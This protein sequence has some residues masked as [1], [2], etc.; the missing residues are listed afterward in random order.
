MLVL[1]RQFYSFAYSFI[2]VKYGS[3]FRTIACA[4]LQVGGE[5]S[6]KKKGENARFIRSRLSLPPNYF[7]F[8]YKQSLSN[9][10]LRFSL[11]K[12]FVIFQSQGIK[13]Q[14]QLRWRR[15]DGGDKGFIQKKHKHELTPEQV[16]EVIRE[17]ENKEN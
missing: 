2:Y 10:S 13:R 8:L 6:V 1:C 7:I 9:I 3:N 17:L 11:G 4:T 14:R 16:F 5:G 12:D 15:W